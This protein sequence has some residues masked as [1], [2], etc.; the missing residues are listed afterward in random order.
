MD[1]YCCK[2]QQTPIIVLQKVHYFG[3]FWQKTVAMLAYDI[4]SITEQSFR[5]HTGSFPIPM[6]L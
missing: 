2:T 3:V 5:W 4:A 6:L 1:C